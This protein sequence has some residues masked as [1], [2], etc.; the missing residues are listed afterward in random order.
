MTTDED[1][2]ELT[3]RA[4]S[5]DKTAFSALAERHQPRARRLAFDMVSN[6]DLAQE[7]T[8]EAV[9]AA[10]L[11]LSHLRDDA[12]FGAWLCGITLNVCRRALRERA[13]WRPLPEFPAFAADPLA[14]L[15]ARER[16]RVV[17]EAVAS[18][19]PENQAAVALFYF[20]GRSLLE[21]A[22]ALQISLAAVKGR[23]HKSRRLIQAQLAPHFP[24]ALPPR[25]PP[26]RS[27]AMIPVSVA[28]VYQFQENVALPTHHFV[29]LLDEAGQR[30]LRVFV[31]QQEAWAISVTLRRAVADR[32]LAH[33]FVVN[34]LEASGFH[35][36]AV[37][38]A[39]LREETFYAV[40]QLRRGRTAKEVDARP[41]D[42]LALAL[43]TNS[44]VF[45]APDVLA[46]VGSEY[47]PDA[48]KGME[49][50]AIWGTSEVVESLLRETL[51]AG[52]DEM[53]LEPDENLTRVR[54][55]FG[56]E[57]R[58]MTTVS[59]E[60]HAPLVA[61]FKMLADMVIARAE[62]PQVGTIPIKMD[63]KDYTAHI[64]VEQ[65]EHGA[66]VSIHFRQ[67]AG[68]HEQSGTS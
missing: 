65:A 41:S 6:A 54:H 49:I 28:G 57:W 30:M 42:A 36:E 24:D 2:A 46:S 13:A 7:L 12:K 40:V 48:I 29:V 27:L 45:V 33:D 9:V 52:A 39:A 35:V 60:L 37:Q 64:T 66:T 47:L 31:G 10:Y 15:E 53:R 68:E 56:G 17:R 44:P 34:V 19:S 55:R 11:S 22:D 32:P 14:V 50:G 21:I 62:T 18:L 43:R 26:K 59:K 1:E 61:H 63:S 16:Q 5:G 67:A 3:R 51:Q 38:I 23:L 25:R 8:Q 4:R 58:D 20:D